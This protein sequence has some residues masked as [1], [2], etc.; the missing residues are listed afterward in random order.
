MNRKAEIVT[1]SLIAVAVIALLVI[2]A[3]KIIPVLKALPAMVI[4]IQSNQ[5]FSN[6]ANGDLCENNTVCISGYCNFNLGQYGYGYYGGPLGICSAAPSVKYPGPSHEVFNLS[7]FYT[8]NLFSGTPLDLEPGDEIIIIVNGVEHRAIV[9]SIDSSQ[10]TITLMIYSNPITVTLKEG[11]FVKVDVDQDGF[12]DV[13]INFIGFMNGHAN[14][15]FTKL[16]AC[17]NGK[18]ESGESQASCCKDCGCSTGEC[19]DNACV[20]PQVV[21]PATPTSP[22]PPKVQPPSLPAYIQSSVTRDVTG[23]IISFAAVM[24]VIVGI[25]IFLISRKIIKTRKEKELF[26]DY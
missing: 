2:L 12:N 25:I 3:P 9:Y 4:G 8:Y 18:C 26:W 22:A 11:E 16:T 7:T 5:C 14:V 10:G 17:G 13:E 21:P 23:E 15:A 24:I 19:K 1:I 20:V 6:C